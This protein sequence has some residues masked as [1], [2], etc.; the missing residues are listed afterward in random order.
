MII[1][2]IK[3]NKVNRS[4]PKKHVYV[5]RYILHLQ[6]EICTHLGITSPRLNRTHQLTCDSLLQA[7]TGKFNPVQQFLY[8]DS[9][10]CLPEENKEAVLT[11]ESCK[12]VR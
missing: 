3:F 9:Y 11:E 5:Y 4:P 1:A 10:E 6:K 7:C 2:C 12:L 8:F